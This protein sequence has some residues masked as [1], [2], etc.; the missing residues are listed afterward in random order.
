MVDKQTARPSV[1][2]NAIRNSL[3]ALPWLWVVTVLP[4]VFFGPWTW[5]SLVRTVPTSLTIIVAGTPVLFLAAL[6]AE[7]GRARR[8]ATTGDTSE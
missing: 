4:F 3:K 7:R 8:E 5:A 1:V 6:F 2:R